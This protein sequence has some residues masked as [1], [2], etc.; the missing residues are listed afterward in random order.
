MGGCCSE[1]QKWEEEGGLGE[2][3]VVHVVAELMGQIF[4]V[5]VLSEQQEGMEEVDLYLASCSEEVQGAVEEGAGRMATGFE[6][7][8][9]RPD[10][11]QTAG[12]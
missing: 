11:V 5:V 8:G 6:R 2:D 1:G 7:A 3:P 10:E 4:E 9:K 12:Y